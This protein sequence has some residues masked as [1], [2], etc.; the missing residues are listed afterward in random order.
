MKI[1][2]KK[3]YTICDRFC[4]SSVYMREKLFRNGE[5]KRDQGREILECELL[6]GVDI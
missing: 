6:R 4:D 2:A 1:E 5:K 3:K